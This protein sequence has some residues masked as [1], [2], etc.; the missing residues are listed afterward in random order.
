MLNALLIANAR[1][2]SAGRLHGID[3]PGRWIL[4]PAKVTP[5]DFIAADLVAFFA[6][7]GTLQVTL[8]ELLRE[9]PVSSLPPVALLPFGTTN[10]NARDLNR[11]QRRRAAADRLSRIIRTGNFESLTRPLLRVRQ[12]EHTEYGF[13]FGLGVIAEVVSRWHG[14]R[15][16]SAATN[17]LRT[18]QAMVS[19]LRRIESISRIELDG[20]PCEVYGLLA[21]TLD[22]LLFGSRPFWGG[23]RPGDLRLT[24]V[25]AHAPH[26]LR[27]APAL[28]RGRSDMARIPGYESKT[29]D[30]VELALD[31]P[32][33]IDGEIFHTKG[34]SLTITRSE[35]LTWIVL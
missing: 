3:L 32:Y 21:T 27:H 35:P 33:I 4:D 19:G 29:V 30:S 26:L 20:A 24:W 34:Q 10:M 15:G 31:G 17:Q 8:S 16:G 28:L 11:T 7:D 23:G 12:G 1:S 5:D 9:L 18:L 2:G 14:Q 6:G 22:R 13:F 25:E